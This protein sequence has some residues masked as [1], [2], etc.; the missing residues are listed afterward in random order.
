VT[1][2]AGLSA[3]LSN[4]ATVAAMLPVA[5]GVGR[6]L[7]LSPSRLFMPLAFA[8]ILGGTLTLIGT[9]TNVVIAAALPRFGQSSWTSFEL[10]PA[11]LPGTALGLLYLLVVGPR[12]LPE[13]AA[14]T[15]DLYRLREHVSEV[16]LPAG[17]PW[18]GSALRQLR[19]G[20]DLDV[21]V[22]GRIEAGTVNRLGP[23]ERLAA[24]DRLLVKANQQALLR[25]KVRQELDLVVDRKTDVA[26]SATPAVHEVVL[27]HGSRLAG[28]TLRELAFGSR[29]AVMVVA[30]FRRG[31]PLLDRISSVPLR[32]GDLLLVQGDLGALGELLRAGHLIPGGSLVARGWYAHLGVGGGFRWH[33]ARRRD[34]SRALPPG[35]PHRGGRGSPRALLGI[36]PGPGDQR[37]ESHTLGGLVMKRLARLPVVGDH[38]EWRGFGFEVVDMDGRRVDKV[39][40]ERLADGGDQARP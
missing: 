22:L 16:V 37:P 15:T 36:Q 27:P 19:A 28:R 7:R 25:L 24:G 12:L 1:A 2:T 6:R 33:V 17:S 39:L 26:T 11:A 18:I 29:S 21:L 32:E 23:D 40:V 8:S 10:A 13:R 4:T 34:R 5:A 38:I 30:L 20:A 9:S 14:A 31:E 35:C 3:L